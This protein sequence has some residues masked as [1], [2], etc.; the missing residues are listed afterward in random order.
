MI[1]AQQFAKVSFPLLEFNKFFERAPVAR[2]RLKV[3]KTFTLSRRQTFNKIGP[4]KF[5]EKTH[6]ERDH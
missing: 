6:R 5:T 2:D 3:P 4:T 1:V